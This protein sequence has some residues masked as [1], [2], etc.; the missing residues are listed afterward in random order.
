M[1]DPEFLK[2]LR[3]PETQQTLEVAD[4]AVVRALNEKIAAGRVSSRG[5][6]AVSQPCDGGL[7]RKDGKVLYPIRQE[8]PVMIVAESLPLG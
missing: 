2:L 3:C 6:I 1:I 8:I 4:A 5:G 7:V